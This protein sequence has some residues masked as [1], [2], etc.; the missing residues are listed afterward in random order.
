MKLS[1]TLWSLAAAGIAAVPLM[2]ISHAATSHAAS[3]PVFAANASISVNQASQIATKVVGGGSV[4]NV[5]LDHYQGKSVYDIHVS[6]QGQIWDVKVSTSSG[7]VLLKTLSSEQ[8]SSSATSPSS[9]S[10][11]S[12]SPSSATSSSSSLSS[13]A[14]VSQSKAGTIAVN[15]VGGG[16]VTHSSHDHSGGVLV[17]DVHVLYGS[18]VYDVKVNASTGTVL[19][20]KMSQ[21]SVSASS[22]PSKESQTPQS[23]A[24]QSPE[25]VSA[26]KS[27]S[28]QSS[29]TPIASS[30]SSSIA[31]DTKTTAVP[32][33]YQSAVSQ[34]LS[35]AGG[36]LKWVKFIKAGHGGVQMNVKIILSARKTT[37]IIDQFNSSGMLVSQK[38]SS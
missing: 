19:A 23:E 24:P 14:S 5:S 16:V 7:A 1:T 20:K 3:S 28:A 31:W 32:S 11:S 2:A 17:W 36:T 30:G 35:S 22:S 33:T 12:T 4:S 38:S 26:K 15:A 18:T 37:K 8:P 21:E 34:A 25:K 13:V 10:P 6:Y 27:E 29:S 9:S